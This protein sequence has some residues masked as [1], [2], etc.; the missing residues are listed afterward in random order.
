MGSGKSIIIEYSRSSDESPILELKGNVVTLVSQRS[1]SLY[2][3]S[4]PTSFG[5]FIKL[6]PKIGAFAESCI[7]NTVTTRDIPIEYCGILRTG[8][9]L[10]DS[11]MTLQIG[12]NRELMDLHLYKQGKDKIDDEIVLFDK[13]LEKKPSYDELIDKIE[14]R[15]IFIK[16]KAIKELLKFYSPVGKE[17]LCGRIKETIMKK[18][19]DLVKGFLGGIW[20]VKDDEFLDLTIE[21]SDNYGPPIILEATKILGNYDNEKSTAALVRAYSEIPHIPSRFDK[22]ATFDFTFERE[23]CLALCKMSSEKIVPVLYRSLL[24]G[25]RAKEEALKKLLSLEG[26]EKIIE[27]FNNNVNIEHDWRHYT[28]FSNN[29]RWVIDQ[30]ESVGNKNK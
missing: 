8:L 20:E 15:E 16:S 23:I 7:Q 22:E 18:D 25:S 24:N 17:Y 27:Y 5:V 13:T 11:N 30:L 28:N 2:N 9:R 29:A 26:K 6:P 1:Y 12:P 21:I 14:K 3:V 10:V 4:S 19:P